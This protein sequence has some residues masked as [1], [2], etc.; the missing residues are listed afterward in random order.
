[1]ENNI[2]ETIETETKEASFGQYALPLSILVAAVMISGTLLYTKS[3]AGASTRDGAGTANVGNNAGVVAGP[4]E[5]TISDDDTILGDKDAKVAIV[6]FSDFQ[7]PFCR[8]FYNGAFDQ[9]KSEYIDTGKAY[10]VYKHMPLSF[11]PAAVVSAQA[12]ECVGE[13]GKFWEFHD[14]IYDEQAKQ[15]GGTIE[16]SRVELVAWAGDIGVNVADLNSCL[17]DGRYLD[18]IEQH[19][20]E[21]SKAGVLGTPSFV[22][23]GQSISGAQPFAAFQ[24]VIEAEL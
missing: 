1:M 2:K 6:E 22:I 14:K 11:H 17:D 15:G 12:A 18:K 13:Q 9:I 20:T 5:V 4:A 8:S 16:Y 10:L 19:I 3:S 21:A 23:N 7:C 24:A